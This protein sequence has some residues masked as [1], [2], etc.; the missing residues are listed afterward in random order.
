M[1]RGRLLRSEIFK[2]LM[3][4][5]MR[6]SK[7]DSTDQMPDEQRAGG[8]DRS[9]ALQLRDAQ[10]CQSLTHDSVSRQQLVFAD[11]APDE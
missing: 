1:R 6:S 2:G 5:E 11:S 8:P 9:G 7:T 4:T 3:D 10:T